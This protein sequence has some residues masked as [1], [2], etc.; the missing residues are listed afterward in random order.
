MMPTCRIALIVVVI[1]VPQAHA[2]VYTW[3]FENG[4]FD[5]RSLVPLG[6]GA[7]NLLRPTKN[8]L[9]ITVPAGYEVKTVGLSP[10]FT[11]VGDFE[12]TLD[13]TILNRTQPSAGFGTGPSLYLSTG[14][15]NDPAASL[16]RLLRP[17]GRD[18]YG[19]FAARVED[20]K[21]LPSARLF[22]AP[23][24]K[25]PTGRLQLKRVKQDIFYSVAD[26][27]QSPL[28]EIAHLPMGGGEVTLLRIGVSQSDP[29]SAA[30]VVLHHLQIVADE[31]PHLP[32][33]TDRTAQLY[34][35]RYQPPPKPPTYRWLWQSLAAV[36]IVG[37][38]GSWLWWRRQR[39]G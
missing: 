2:A 29:E 33:E 8:G 32:S 15:T 12:I 6:A 23:P 35:P 37:G 39:I 36:L 34:R 17:D 21:R 1:A 4:H 3:D 19:V 10:R 13:F 20:G 26:S 7:V 38:T 5:N 9:Q 24:N 25:Q 28:R 31:L 27:L 11:L 14:S 30:V 16:G 18:I 22:D